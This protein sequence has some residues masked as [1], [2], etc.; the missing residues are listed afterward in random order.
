MRPHIGVLPLYNAEKQIV[1]I[2]PLYFSA[3]EQAGGLASLLPLTDDPALWEEYCQSFD[4]FVFTGGQDVDPALYGQKKLPQCSYQVPQRDNQEFFMMRRLRELDKPVLGI[5][6]GSQ[7]MNVACGGTLYQDLATQAPSAVVHQQPKPYELPHHQVT[8]DRDSRLY[9]LTG[10]EHL[11]VNSVHHQAI[12]APA[13]DFRITAR[14][15]DGIAEAL[16]LPGARFFLGVQWHPEHMWQSYAS[17]RGIWS[18]FIN[19]CR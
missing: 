3:I 16:E 6:R 11:S 17:A 9:R 13:P 2:Q 12:L 8:I 15:E 5:C 4:G 14:A 1:W 10:T 19:A 18:G 7:I